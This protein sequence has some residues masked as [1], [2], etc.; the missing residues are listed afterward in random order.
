MFHTRLHCT[1]VACYGTS[2]PPFADVFGWTDLC[3]D[4]RDA[5]LDDRSFWAWDAPKCWRSGR[6][7]CDEPTRDG[8]RRRPPLRHSIST[9]IRSRKPGRSKTGE[10]SCLSGNISPASKC[11][12]GSSRQ[13][14]TR[15]F[16]PHTS[17][18]LVPNERSNEDS[19]Y[20]KA[21]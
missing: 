14:K 6:G 4:L 8:D 10:E 16:F 20:D 17:L 9:S 13:P 3:A 15:C 12:P 2:R 19:D 1:F 7:F 18:A 5:S 11:D 21:E